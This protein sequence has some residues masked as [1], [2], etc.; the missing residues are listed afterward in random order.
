[1][2]DFLKTIF[3]NSKNLN[4]K[5]SSF[6]NLKRQKPILTLFSAIENYSNKSEIRYVGGCIRKILNN[7][8]VDDIDFAV[9][10]KPEEC[11]EALKK[12]NIN[13]YETGIEHGTVTAVIENNKFEI[14]SLR[15]DISTDGRHAKVEFSDNWFEDASR[16]DFTINSIYADVDGNLYDPFNG[17]KDIELGKVVFI[18]NVEQRIKEDYLRILRYIRFYLNYSNTNHDETVKTII[19][20]NINGITNISS[21]RLLDEFKKIINS[22]GFLKLFKDSF[23]E[24]IIKLIFPQFKNFDYLKKINSFSERKI[25]EVDYIFLVALLVIDNT[26]NV[27][28]FLFKFNLSNINKKRIL[29]LKQFYDK[30]IDKNFFSESNLWKIFYYNGKQSLKDI[31][32]YEIFK[33]K[34]ENKKI[35]NLISFFEDKSVPIFPIK[36]K[37]IMEKYDISEGK[38]LGTVLKKLENKWVESNF[39]ISESEVA[40][41]IKN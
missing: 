13:Y 29:F 38:F 41:I 2:I 25:R 32:Y 9:N 3:L 6:N 36:A 30:K 8:I 11:I 23:S 15:K 18:G 37:Y 28:Y 12:K 21:E 4:E 35:I 14:T 22:P 20:K 24:E 34:K 7:E 1:M 31:L 27:N 26:D 33:S 5:N 17:K 10:L 40:Q 39:K 16:R 19:K